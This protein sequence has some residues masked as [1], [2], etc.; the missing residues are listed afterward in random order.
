MFALA[1]ASLILRLMELCQTVWQ[2]WFADDA[3]AA[4][5][6]EWLNQAM[7]GCIVCQLHPHFAYNPMHPRLSFL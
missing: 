6:C 7:V 2:V 4:A 5:T 1:V 3:A